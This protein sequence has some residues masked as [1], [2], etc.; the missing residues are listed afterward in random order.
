MF[1]KIKDR[2]KSVFAKSEEVI[3]EEESIIE[4]TPVEEI[5][6]EPKKE[7]PKKQDKEKPKEKKKKET[8]KEV[9]PKEQEI[10]ETPIEEPKE[11]IIEE[12]QKEEKKEG[13]FKKLFKKKDEEEEQEIEQIEE[14]LLEGVDE[15]EKEKI[16][17]GKEIPKEIKEEK[18]KEIE[19]QI[20][21]EEEQEKEEIKEVEEEGFFKKTFS[22][23]KAKK[24]TTED[25]EK[26]WLEL[27]IFLL[28]INIA[29]EIVE[30]I[31]I[32]LR[33][34]LIDNSFDRFALSEKIREVMVEEVSKVLEKREDDLLSK[35]K[36]INQ[37]GEVAKILILGVNGTGKTTSIAKIVKLFQKNNL[38]L[39]VAAADTFR[40]AAV[41]QLEEHSIKA[42]FKLIQHKGGS[43]PA[44]VAYD[45]IEHAKAKNLNVV[46]IDT[47]GRMPNNP[48]LMKELEKIER[49]SKSDINLFIGDSIS[50]NDLIDQ[51]ELF[52]KVVGIDGMILT[53][54][55]TDERPG[56]VVTAAYSIEKPIYYLG[57]GQG[58]DDLVKFEGKLIAE[59]L[60]EIEDK[61]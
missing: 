1:G 50:G 14:D 40:A 24:L 25:F 21:K 23:L 53:K 9:K 29:Y 42:G 18:T 33:E 2:L 26:I 4:E 7:K 45:A 16:K 47:A 44:A 35:I 51:I 56:S 8:K 6:E 58:Y 49:V 5:I 39:V 59:K 57:T 41:E 20:E 32:H 46:M 30:K 54:T 61:D 52:D 36:E 34:S 55:D 12:E 15:K 13:F 31:E 3:E 10:E 38:S 27:E 22:K 19:K 37:K 28:E 43:D 60:F 17:K 11:Q 48:N